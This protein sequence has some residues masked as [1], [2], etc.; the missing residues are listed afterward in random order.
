L[1]DAQCPKGFSDEFVAF[2]AIREEAIKRIAKDHHFIIGDD[3]IE[4]LR[5][6]AE[7]HPEKYSSGGIYD[8][9]KMFPCLSPPFERFFIEA[10]GS[11][12]ENGW[13]FEAREGLYHSHFIDKRRELG[14][15]I[16]HLEHTRWTLILMPCL[17]V[18]DTGWGPTG[19]NIF[20]YLDEHG[21]IIEFDTIAGMLVKSVLGAKEPY[22]YTDEDEFKILVANRVPLMTLSLMNARNTSMVDV[23]NENNISKRQRRRRRSLRKHPKLK[24]TTV[25][26]QADKP[27]RA[28]KGQQSEKNNC[29]STKPLHK[30]RGFWRTFDPE[31]KGAFGRGDYRPQW[32]REHKRGNEKNGQTVTTYNVKAPR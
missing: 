8:L 29:T 7:R 5:A 24:F 11:G 32:V 19:D 28:K 9:R 14:K 21:A 12:V 16:R 1:Q 26:I 15:P 4:F 20:L 6:D 17:S 2:L 25:V 31:G 23:S 3:I 27:K 18:P 22:T 13:A 30:C 10:S